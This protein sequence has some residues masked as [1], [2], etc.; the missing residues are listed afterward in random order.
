M[1]KRASNFI[2]I[3]SVLTK[4]TLAN[5]LQRFSPHET[6][7]LT[8]LPSCFFPLPLPSV[9]PSRMSFFSQSSVVRG[10]VPELRWEGPSLS[11]SSVLSCS[12]KK[13]QVDDSKIT[14]L[15]GMLFLFLVE[16]VGVLLD[17]LPF[18]HLYTGDMSAGD[19]LW[20]EI[21]IEIKLTL[22]FHIMH[23]SP[24]ESEHIGATSQNMCLSSHL[25]LLSSLQGWD[26]VAHLHIH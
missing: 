26:S 5:P 9:L 4:T 20:S 1:L 14:H 21:N 10:T 25:F 22:A 6:P 17:L 15:K 2:S 19:F 16:W 18:E 7:R 24:G 13:V 12:S 8:A 23:Q 11:L 3:I